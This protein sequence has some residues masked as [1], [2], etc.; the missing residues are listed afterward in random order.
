[1]T[2][3]ELTIQQNKVLERIKD[4]LNSD[5]SVFILRGYAGTGKTTM[6]KV[7]S[8]YI[9]Q[10]REVKLMAPTGR[11]ARILCDKTGLD[12]STIHRA[13]YGS[14]FV[15]SKKVDTIAESEFKLVFPVNKS[16]FGGSL[17]T[18]VDEASMVCS[19]K[20]EHELYVFGS[21]NLL[22]DLLEFVRPSFGGKIIFVGD[23]A[24]LPPVGESVSN[25]LTTEYF[26]SRNL[27]V[28]EEELTDV[29]R[30]KNDSV[31][32]KNAM[33]IRDILK[34][35]KRNH[36]VFEEREG[37]V[38]RIPSG[39]FLKKYLEHRRKSGIHDSVIICYSNRTASM[40]NKDI[41][42]SLYGGEVPLKKNDILLITQNNYRLGRMNG[43]FVPILDVGTRIKQSTPVY[44]QIGGEKQRIIITINF[45]QVTVLNGMGEPMQCM[46][47]EDLL[48]TDK[49]SISIDEHRALYINFCM[50]HPELK[51]GSEEFA[52]ALMSDP[53]YN[54]I[55]AKY[56]YAVTGHKSQ[57][58][59]WGK[60]F[61]DY[62]GRTGLNDD[63]LR[64]AYTVT[65]RAQN[66]LYITNLP[67][68][69]PFSKFRIDS[70]QKCRNMP[71]ECRI[72]DEIGNTPFHDSSTE[73]YLRAKYLCI[74][75]NMEFTPYRVQYVI[76][77]P[78]LEIYQIQT[79]N[80][81]DRFD[82]HYKAGGIF[83]PAKSV[84]S[85]EHTEQILLH[86][87]DERMMPIV[88]DYKPSDEIREKLY[89]TIRSACDGLSIQLT[90][91]VEHDE[92]YSIIYYMRTSGAF[93]Y[94]K[95]YM[96]GSGFVTYAKPM[97]QYGENDSE[98]IALINEIKNHMI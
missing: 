53:F 51:Q 77:K 9:S 64:W 39:E 66:T 43:E 74:M 73:N 2:K 98:L 96:N 1:M 6:V 90:N 84:S 32:L 3:M 30:Q 18:I 44:S 24:Q 22:E 36:L 23:P 19:R 34:K 16:E 29:I 61:V 28:V 48:T 38:E 14:A 41:R 21:D 57:G 27:K 69:T 97:S 88:F 65:T 47:I 72:I 26:K 31:I 15:V 50:R 46:L 93:S 49:A 56:G 5:A 78:Y 70:I 45:V 60:V 63:C 52:Q 8:N 40:Y 25:A 71:A 37:D 67:H 89:Y 20:I 54:A 76:S 68:V 81:S 75:Q 10:S 4:F 13:I 59:E 58:G 85:N 86:L 79:P 55:R 62:S 11:A 80:G 82:L 33:M 87:N 17:V 12:A 83:L 91:V 35:E 7:I 92:D 42:V 94:I 95:V